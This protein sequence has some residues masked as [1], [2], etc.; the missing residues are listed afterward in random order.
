[1][2]MDNIR[3]RAHVFLMCVCF[4]A[5]VLL[6]CG[7][8]CSQPPARASWVQQQLIEDN[9]TMYRRDPH[10]LAGKFRKMKTN[11]Y[12]YFRGTVR[13]YLR[14][15]MR[16]HTLAVPTKFGTA[17]SA[18]VACV[19]DPHPE[20]I[21]TYRNQKGE[22]L[23]D[24][25]DFDGATYAPYYFD[26]RRLTVGFATQAIRANIHSTAPQEYDR[27]LKRVSEGYTDAI[28]QQLDKKPLRIRPKKGFGII[29]DDLFKRAREQGA[30]GRKLNEYTNVQSGQRVMFYG[31]L[32]PSE[33]EGVIRDELKPPTDEESAMIKRLV[34]S[35]APTRLQKVPLTQLQV[36][37]ISRR[38]GAGVSSYPRLR[39]Y[40]LVEG[41]TS[42]VDDDWL[43]E[44]KEI[45]D[46]PELPGF[47]RFPKH[48]FEHNA[49][50]VVMLQRQLQESDTNDV[51]LGWASDA[52]M[53]FR[54]RHRVGYQK[55]YST[56]RF[57][58]KYADGK[59]SVR[60]L[61]DFA[62]HA[63]RLLARSHARAELLVG[64]KGLSVI[65]EAI[66]QRHAEFVE[67]TFR[68]AKQYAA[69]QSKDFAS[70]GETLETEGQW[71]GFRFP[72]LRW[73]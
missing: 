11:I 36:K 26:V 69:Q 66:G 38:Y 70:F 1:M 17:K 3:E 37:G 61:G 51:H 5:G 34:R 64:G 13:L 28:R 40:V 53:V 7:V 47:Q 52:P 67:E 10:A 23:I 22:L 48:R 19:I 63:G 57:L 18:Y 20:N 60:D 72:S 43:L 32:E 45:T 58:E 49:Q 4:V 71:L 42:S 59:W 68:F 55:N 30:E 21:G 9:L 6:L 39:Y 35:Y 14:D 2:C 8:G 25:N 27:L 73:Y 33:I 15:L 41:P 50:R 46:I 54:V 16:T 62:Y 31:V 24:F 12:N 65:A 56:D 29:L 44:F